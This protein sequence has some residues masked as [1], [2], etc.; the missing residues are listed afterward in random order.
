MA[1]YARIKKGIVSR[2]IRRG[3]I[4]LF[5]FESLVDVWKL[6]IGNIIII[7]IMLSIMI[8]FFQ[9]RD[10]K[11]VWTWLLVLY[12]IPVFGIFIYFILGQDYRKSKMFK[13]KEMEDTL[14]YSVARQERFF[15]ERTKGMESLYIYNYIKLIR[16]NLNSGASMF[17][18]YN[19]IAIFNNGRDKFKNLISD[20]R[21]AKRYIHIEYY[22]IKN[23][24][25]FDAL[26]KE[27]IL[28]ARQGVEV[29]ILGDGMGVRFM[30]KYKWEQL[31]SEGIKVGIFFPA[32][33]GWINPR[34]NYRNHRKI[35]VIDDYIGY[36]GG[37]NIGKE[38]IGADP[39]FGN[40]RDTHLRLTGESVL[41][42]EVRFAL[43][44][45][46]SVK[47]NLFADPKYNINDM[48][49]EFINNLKKRSH[50]I[51]CVQ[52]IASGPDSST[53]Q[54]RNNFIELFGGAKHHIYIQTPYF[55]PD[56]A[57]LSALIVAIRSGIDV[58]IMIPCKPDHPFVYW[59]TLS[60]AG[61]LLY[62]GA[63]VYTYENGF[64]HAKTVM[65]DSKCACVGTANMDIRSFELNFEVNATI[66]DEET[67]EKLENDFINDISLSK[68]LTVE[69]FEKRGFIRRF[70]EQFSRLLSPLL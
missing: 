63:K 67:T 64:L 2:Y 10:P 38:Y 66:Y 70:K 51:C 28:K 1:N 56:E 42:L 65:V 16:Y 39:R 52:I 13:V 47:E 15:A 18:V 35:V 33:L 60:W 30:P 62:E 23:D 22:I 41:S 40:W 32:M 25:L 46:Y 57:V 36:I 68:E 54:V 29:R 5:E 21:S 24:Y 8:V 59:A 37:F 20:I 43:D 53:K 58:R 31:K 17:T 44:W 45:N 19:K 69:I 12:F 4:L 3:M 11:T 6:I 55:I 14:H 34:M 7:N 61:T 26:S 49:D 48:Y 9:R 27:L 50:E